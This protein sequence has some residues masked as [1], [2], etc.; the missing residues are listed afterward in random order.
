MF[1]D[2]PE[3]GEVGEP[4]ATGL[5]EEG[6]E[7]EEEAVD[8]GSEGGEEDDS[9]WP[10]KF[11]LR[12]SLIELWPIFLCLDFFIYQ[13]FKCSAWILSEEQTRVQFETYQ[14]FWSEWFYWARWK[15]L[16]I[17]IDWKQFNGI[18]NQ[19]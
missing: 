5:P 10:P 16:K 9:D 1:L 14:L 11:F 4:L 18:V 19:I 17:F 6:A 13:N 3:E 7:E 15:V 2:L 8:S 12:F